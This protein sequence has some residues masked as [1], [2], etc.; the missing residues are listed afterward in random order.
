M[1]MESASLAERLVQRAASRNSLLPARR[2]TALGG[3]HARELWARCLDV[4]RT[5]AGARAAWAGFGAL[6]FAA[7]LYRLRL[8][9]ALYTAAPDV[10]V[11]LDLAASPRGVLGQLGADALLAAAGALLILL[12]SQLGDH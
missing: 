8:C 10:L 2:Y 5:V 4:A 12:L 1:V 9:Y 11:A 3:Q 7:L 6:F